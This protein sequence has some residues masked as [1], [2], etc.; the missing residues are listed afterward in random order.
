MNFV[1]NLG[2]HK[3]EHARGPCVVLC[4]TFCGVFWGELN[5]KV[6][7]NLEWI[8]LKKQIILWNLAKIRGTK[9][10]MELLNKQRNFIRSEYKP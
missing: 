10:L 5:G 9:K 6:L 4:P 3:V 2:R 1:L 7:Q 8:F